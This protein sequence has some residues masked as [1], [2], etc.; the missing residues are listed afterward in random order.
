MFLFLSLHNTHM[1]TT[2]VVDVEATFRLAHHP[3][4][5]SDGWV[6]RLQDITHYLHPP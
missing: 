2:S 1:H 3:K 6:W 4:V 5:L